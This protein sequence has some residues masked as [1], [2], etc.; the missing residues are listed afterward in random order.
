MLWTRASARLRGRNWETLE[1]WRFAAS[2]ISCI[3]SRVKLIVVRVIGIAK[4]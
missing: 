3:P 1:P 2:W 4:S